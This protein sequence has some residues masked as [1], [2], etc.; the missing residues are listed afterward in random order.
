MYYLIIF[1]GS[2]QCSTTIQPLLL[3]FLNPRNNNNK[4]FVRINSIA[5][6]I[7]FSYIFSLLIIPSFFY[8][9]HHTTSCSTRQKMA[10]YY[11]NYYD[12]Q[13]EYEDEQ[14]VADSQTDLYGYNNNNKFRPQRQNGPS[15]VSAVFDRPARQA[16]KNNSRAPINHRRSSFMSQDFYYLP[17]SDQ[18]NGF[19][20][21]YQQ[22]RH[23]RPHSSS[24]MST[25]TVTSPDEYQHYYQDQQQQQPGR[26]RGSQGNKQVRCGTNDW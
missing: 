18:G 6:C 14:S 15:M 8:I 21:A 10:A 24:Y 7:F 25:E 4:P 3:P 2:K 23:P 26:R 9:Y 13:P 17:E 16:R 22:S 11:R 5:Q 12:H 20:Y 19:N 1:V